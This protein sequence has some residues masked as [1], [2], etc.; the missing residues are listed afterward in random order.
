MRAS[1]LKKIF[2]DIQDTVDSEWF[3]IF[4]SIVSN[5]LAVL[6][7]CH[8]LAC[9]WFMLGSTKIDGYSSWISEFDV[10]YGLKHA[11]WQFQYLAAFHWALAQ[12]TPGGA[13]GSPC[14]IPEY[15]LAIFT[16]LFGMVYCSLFISGL[17]QQR[18]HLQQLTSKVEKECWMLRRY[19]RQHGVA[20][21]LT[22][23]TIRYIDAVVQPMLQKVQR[24]DVALMNYL[25]RP[26]RLE[27]QAE[28]FHKKVLHPF[29]QQLWMK[30]STLIWDLF[31]EVINESQLGRTDL[32]F[33]EGQVAREM[34]FVSQGSLAYVAHGGNSSQNIEVGDWC[35][36]P[37]LWVP[38][39]HKGE[40]TA[41]DECFLT[42]M[43]SSKF[44]SV[45]IDH[46]ERTYVKRCAVAYVKDLNAYID[47]GKVV[48]DTIRIS[49]DASSAYIEAIRE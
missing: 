6:G 16:L 30:R 48:G 34:Y 18:M 7:S 8:Y 4:I 12:F 32:L 49:D 40:L 21:E 19:L 9:L 42:S 15:L 29:I 11:D 47:A 36:E 25:S 17:T 35:C 13:Q 41:V 44:R 28:I 26:L 31:G 46:K 24:Q 1:K 23:R 27:V 3:S 2:R 10:Y 14:N 39:V 33:Q 37:V 22:F 43:D 20:K 5:L 45:V 38:W